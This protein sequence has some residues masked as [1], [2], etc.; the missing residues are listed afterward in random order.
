MSLVMV[1][2]IGVVLVAAT[3][4]WFVMRNMPGIQKL[5]LETD[6]MQT[7]D[8]DVKIQPYTVDL[9]QEDTVYSDIYTNEELKTSG[10]ATLSSDN[11][12]YDI[13]R[14]SLSVAGKNAEVRI[15]MGQKE[16]NSLES[17]KL[18]PGAYGM[19]TFYIESNANRLNG[20]RI[21]VQP[22]LIYAA[23]TYEEERKQEL[24]QLAEDHIRFYK[25]CRVDESDANVRT[26]SGRVLC[27]EGRGLTGKLDFGSEKTVVLYWYWP[28]E[29]TDIPAEPENVTAGEITPPISSATSHDVESYDLGDTKLGNY[30]TDI[31]FSFAVTGEIYESTSE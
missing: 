11:V 27:G 26:Y 28:Y 20:Y 24:K 4:A 15:D 8:V 2:L 12:H 18:A 7:L 21:Q 19:V 16:M 13:T 14:M 6:G 17:G 29:Y 10:Y 9:E 1:V 25:D 5:A 3:I 30:V 31:R 23:D 22:E